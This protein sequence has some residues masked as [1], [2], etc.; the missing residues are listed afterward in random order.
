LEEDREETS[1]VTE[2]TQLKDEA[3]APTS[4]PSQTPS[5]QTK[6]PQ[7]GQVS[8]ISGEADMAANTAVAWKRLSVNVANDVADAITTLQD[9]HGW[10]ISDVIRRAISAYKFIDEET[11]EEGSKILIERKNGEVREVQFLH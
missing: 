8:G 11:T 10:T 5:D 1:A 3:D 4:T 2:T 9:K 7:G 6:N